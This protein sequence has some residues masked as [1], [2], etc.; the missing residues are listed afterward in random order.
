MTERLETLGSRDRRRANP[1]GAGDIVFAKNGHA[2]F[3]L[4]GM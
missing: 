3:I 1:L 2:A 4:I